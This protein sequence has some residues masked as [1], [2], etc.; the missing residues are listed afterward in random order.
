MIVYVDVFELFSFF[1]SFNFS[2][3]FLCSSFFSFPSLKSSLFLF[4]F[5]F[6]IFSFLLSFLCPLSSFLFFLPF[7]FY[8][9]L[10]PLSSFFFSVLCLNFLSYLLS[11]FPS[12]SSLFIIFF[13]FCL[14]H[15][16]HTSIFLFLHANHITI[17]KLTN[18]NPP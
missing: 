13:H 16:F 11:S 3:F 18:T 9:F 4:Y 12:T 10:C 1:P 6:F 8:F 15:S 17:N 7:I 14:I 2:F 5:P